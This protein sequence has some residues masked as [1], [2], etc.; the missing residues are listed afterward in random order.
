ME[1]NIIT[2]RS[3]CDNIVP[4]CRPPTEFLKTFLDERYK[5]KRDRISKIS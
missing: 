3:V 5:I 4:V 2:A 1:N